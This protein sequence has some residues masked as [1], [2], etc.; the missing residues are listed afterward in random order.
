VMPRRPLSASQNRRLSRLK[1][2]M[3]DTLLSRE[4]RK[5]NSE[6]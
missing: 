6:L 3:T 1:K 2:P 5:T 4:C